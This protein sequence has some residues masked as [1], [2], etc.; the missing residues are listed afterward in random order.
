ML[1]KIFFWAALFWTLIILYL[2]LIKAS[3]IPKINVPNFDK[4]VHAFLHFIFTLLWFFYFKKKIGSLK[5]YELL[6]VSLVLS[7]FFGI[8]IELMQR[9]FTTT[10]T[11]DVFDVIANLSGASIAVIVIVLINKQS[12]II[13][14]I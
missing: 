10:R 12:R 4:A 6:I 3:D 8:A 5:I 11:A 9:Y 2:C 1:K 13:D 7:F 14:K